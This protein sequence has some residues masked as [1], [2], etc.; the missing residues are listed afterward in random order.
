[1]FNISCLCLLCL[2]TCSVFAVTFGVTGDSTFVTIHE[3]EAVEE[4]ALGLS[5]L[6]PDDVA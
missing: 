1:M 6:T 2:F 5:E 3:T 4:T